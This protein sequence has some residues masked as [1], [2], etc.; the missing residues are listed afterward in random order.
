MAAKHVNITDFLE[1][2]P[3]QRTPLGWEFPTVESVNS[4]GKA[5]FWKISVRLFRVTTEGNVFI[6][7]TDDHYTNK[8]ID[9]NLRGWINVDSGIVGGKIKK[10]V[11]TIISTGKNIGKISATNV[12]TQALRDA[13]GMYNKQTKK[14]RDVN[15]DVE[16]PILPVMYPPMLAQV[17]SQQKNLVIDED[18]PVYMQPKFNGVRNVTAIYQSDSMKALLYSRRKNV[19][20]GLDHIREEAIKLCEDHPGLYLDGEIYMHGESLQDISGAARGGHSDKKY[21]YMVYDCFYPTISEKFSERNIQLEGLFIGRDENET[22][23][24]KPV[25]TIMVT[26]RDQIQPIFDR[27]IIEGYEGAMIRLDAPYEFSYNEKHS[28]RLLKMKPVFDA[29]LEITGY[30]ADGKGKS[31]GALMIICKVEPSEM[32]PNI[33]ADKVFPVTPAMEIEERV[34][35]ATK[36]STIE[37]NGKTHFANHWLGK[38][39]IV[40]FDEYSKDGVPQRARTRM[41]ERKWD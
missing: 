10:S 35:L 15:L 26:S 24:I 7:P 19:Y 3:G 38:K 13:L 14:R 22:H 33:P 41:Q 28:K 18:H 40:E 17:F 12:W 31:A 30:S 23:Y 39:I 4:N 2:L 21:D 5:M 32:H 34:A 6:A 29:E 11:P 9:V 16:A 27:W 1:E 20:P 8:V 37:P 36:M 25:E